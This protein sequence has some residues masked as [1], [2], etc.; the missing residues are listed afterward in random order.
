MSL[1]SSGLWCDS[2]QHPI[3]SEPYW[4]VSFNGKPGCHLCELCRKKLM[5]DV[6]VVPV[7]D[8]EPVHEESE[9]CWCEPELIEENEQNGVKV[10]S[11]RRPE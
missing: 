9:K 6:H 11:H 3:L 1:M 7:F 10:W 5:P 2:C 4:N 8:G